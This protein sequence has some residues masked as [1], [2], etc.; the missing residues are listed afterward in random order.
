MSN[1]R[2]LR[3]S[4]IAGALGIAAL[5][6]SSCSSPTSKSHTVRFVVRV[7]PSAVGMPVYLTGNDSALGAWIPNAVPLRRGSDSIWSE[8]MRFRNGTDLEY[9]I[10]AGSWWSQALD[11]NGNRYA[12][13]RL[14]VDRDTTVT[15]EVFDWLNR[16]RNGRA[17]LSAEQFGVTQPPLILDALWKYHP[18]DDSTW[19]SPALNDS[20]WITTDTFIQWDSLSGPLWNGRGWF[21]LP[22]FVDSSL[23]NRTLAIRIEHL[24]ASQLIYNGRRLYSIGTIDSVDG[25]Y[26]PRAMKLWQEIRIEPRHEQVLVVRYANL[27]WQRIRQKGYHPGF[28]LSLAP[29]N[30][31][32]RDAVDVRKNAERQIA[33]TFIPFILALVHFSLYGFMRNQRQHLFYAICMLGFAGVTYFNYLRS[34]VVDVDHILL[35]TTLNNLSGT[36]AVFFGTLTILALNYDRLPRRAWGYTIFA[37]GLGIFGVLGYSASLLTNLTYVLFAFT[38]FESILSYFS[39]K[40]KVFRGGWLLMGGFLVLNVFVVLQILVDFDLIIETPNTTQLYVYG[41]LALA[42]SMSVF[43]SFNFAQLNKD[44]KAQLE[45]V[46]QLSDGAMEQERRAHALALERK[47]IEIESARKSRELESARMLQLSLLPKHVPQIPGFEVAALMKTA[48]EVGGD[49]Y[50]FFEAA[51]GTLTV[52]VGDATG[53][54]LKAGNMVIAA[55]GLLNL[56]SSREDVEEIITAANRAVKQ[57]KLPMMTMCLAVARFR[58]GTMTYSSAGMPPLLVYRAAAKS[59]EQIMLKAMPL[60]AVEQ[61]PFA[62]RSIGLSHGDVVVLTSDGLFEMFDKRR[63]LY[64]MENVMR[65]VADHA[66]ETAESIAESLCADAT[67]WSGGAPL[68][69]DLTIVVVKVKSPDRTAP[70]FSLLSS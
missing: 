54:G 64:G 28:V 40:A 10:T 1:L 32:L 55:K 13:F 58:P 29:V 62:Q 8:E 45:T 37:L 61:F 4:L 16:T 60:G 3:R 27:D 11:S 52:A 7:H 42:V 46:K 23:W 59:C 66:D 15:I 14:S 33:F 21:R 25:G 12:N 19:M 49:Y 56:L 5:L 24:G 9:K 30:S 18:G 34:L 35:A 65:S 26:R 50:D 69:D 39:A 36:A 57:M 63:E 68:A 22:L 47:T 48:S 44:L 41:M 2:Y 17:V 67:A 51:D 53:H 20:G 43:L 31:A 38:T 70:Q 6:L